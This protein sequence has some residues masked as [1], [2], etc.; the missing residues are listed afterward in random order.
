MILC[1]HQLYAVTCIG[2]AISFIFLHPAFRDKKLR[3]DERRTV[4]AMI[5]FTLYFFTAGAV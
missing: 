3:G 2:T 5:T 4:M 1:L